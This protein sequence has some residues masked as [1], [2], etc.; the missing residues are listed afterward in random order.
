MNLKHE[1]LKKLTVRSFMMSICVF[2]AVSGV[3]MIFLRIK[4]IGSIDFKTPFITGKAESGFVGILLI[5][6]SVVGSTLCLCIQKKLSTHRV[7]IERGGEKLEWQG[8]MHSLD[9]IQT[10]SRLLKDE[11]N[12]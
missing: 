2:L 7:T 5:F 10:I 1:L 9:E 12:N 6:S 11:S 8:R 3:V 4:D